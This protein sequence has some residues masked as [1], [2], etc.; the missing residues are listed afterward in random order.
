[1]LTLPTSHRVSRRWI[2][3]ESLRP[4][5]ERDLRLPLSEAGIDMANIAKAMV[6]SL[7]PPRFEQ[8][9]TDRAHR[10]P[11]SASADGVDASAEEGVGA[12]EALATPVDVLTALREQAR[13]ADENRSAQELSEVLV[14][15]QKERER[16]LAKGGAHPLTSSH[17]NFSDEDSLRPEDRKDLPALEPTKTTSPAS[18]YLGDL[19]EAELEEVGPDTA[20]PSVNLV[21]LQEN[22]GVVQQARTKF[23]DP[24]QRQT[25]LE[26]SGVMAARKRLQ[27]FAKQS[28]ENPSL[29]AITRM[30]HHQ[31]QRWM[32]EWYQAMEVRLKE[33]L[34]AMR[35][36]L[37][38]IESS[39]AGYSDRRSI[40]KRTGVDADEVRSAMEQRRLEDA[41]KE[42]YPFLISIPVSRLALV[43]VLEVM[44]LV[45]TT[46]VSDG[47]KMTRACVSLGRTVE[48]EAHIQAMK[49]RDAMIV[50]AGRD[51]STTSRTTSEIDKETSS[52]M[53][54]TDFTSPEAR[55]R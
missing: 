16:Q 35:D 12:F 5:P 45:S 3:Q 18:R 19:S 29:S 21:L 6:W 9:I 26:E 36:Y 30:G 32:W 4:S 7:P 40:I 51:G 37:D 39:A 33:E 44:R 52:L 49:R 54:S 24:Y 47:L 14:R 38:G 15:M 50:K 53:Q 22:L 55:R 42:L 28:E 20:G 13:A 17:P 27:F 46:G 23:S 41:A 10:H 25:W 2:G 43:P 11:P 48:S 34:A 8:Q 31:L 1:M